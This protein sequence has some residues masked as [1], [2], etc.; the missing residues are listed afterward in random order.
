MILVWLGVAVALTSLFAFGEVVLRDLYHHDLEE[1]AEARGKEALAAEIFREHEDAAA[2]AGS[3]K[4]AALATTAVL[5]FLQYGEA[6]AT[7]DWAV[8]TAAGV[9]FALIALAATRW[10]PQTAAAFPTE[11]LVLNTWPAWRIVQVFALPLSA[12][13]DALQWLVVRLAGRAVESPQEELEDEILT[14]VAD[15]KQGGLIED[16]AGDMI[17]GVFDL[18]DTDVAQIMTPRT[19]V[20]MLSLEA[21]REEIVDTATTAGHSRIPIYEENRDDVVGILH[22]KDLLKFSFGRNGE[23]IP[24]RELMRDPFFVP[25]TKPLDD[26]LR[27]FRQQ[28][29]HL[30]VVLD[31]YGGVS[32][33][34]TIE[35][36]LEE[37]VGEIEDEHDPDTIDHVK[38]VNDREAEVSARIHIDELNE[39]L[40]LHLPESDDYETVGGYVLSQLHRIPMP[41]ESLQAEECTI[42]VTAGTRRTLQRLHVARNRAAGAARGDA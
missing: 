6:V 39:R 23:D 5:F 17:E 33:L 27:E 30:A 2:A 14:I 37:I 12:P 11:A 16:D 40:A 20:V 9:V 22:V 24:L 29:R 15:A 26:L 38:V 8:R 25:E 32:G 31:E 21:A 1:I 42:S 3:A 19:D 36:V 4:Y 35:D 13:G 10:G 7:G 34:V 18:A 41:G 28:R